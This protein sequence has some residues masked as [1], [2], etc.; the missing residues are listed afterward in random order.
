MPGEF[1]AQVQ[2]ESDGSASGSVTATWTDQSLV[3]HE[4][5]INITGTKDF[6]WDRYGNLEGL[7]L[8][9]RGKYVTDGKEQTFLATVKIDWADSDPSNGGDGVIVGIIDTS[10]VHVLPDDL[11]IG[12]VARTG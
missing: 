8:N 10:L 1:H 4:V 2:T 7:D 11:H 5:E 3:S 9:G 6:H 12:P